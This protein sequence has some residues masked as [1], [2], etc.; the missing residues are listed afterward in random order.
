MS[1]VLWNWHKATKWLLNRIWIRYV[2]KN[3]LQ[4]D[5]NYLFFFPDPLWSVPHVFCV[6]R[7]HDDGGKGDGKQEYCFYSHCKGICCFPE[8]AMSKL[9]FPFQSLT[10]RTFEYSLTRLNLI[11]RSKITNFQQFLSDGAGR[12]QFKNRSL[13]TF[14]TFEFDCIY[15]ANDQLIIF[16]VSSW[17]YAIS[18]SDPFLSSSDV[19]ILFLHFEEIFDF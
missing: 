9:F 13:E 18:I 11:S 8:S 14:L 17:R 19:T 10:S 3:R 7:R 5:D 1:L 4:S 12:T 6:G 16:C 15:A 2:G